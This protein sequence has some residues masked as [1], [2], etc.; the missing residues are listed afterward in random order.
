MLFWGTIKISASKLGTGHD[1]TARVSRREYGWVM[2]SFP[3]I[4]VGHR[5]FLAQMDGL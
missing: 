5:I 3:P 2:K 1:V 4:W